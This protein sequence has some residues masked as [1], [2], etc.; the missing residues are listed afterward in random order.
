MNSTSVKLRVRLAAI[1][2]GASLLTGLLSAPASA[3]GPAPGVGLLVHNWWNGPMTLNIGFAQYMI[4][5]YG[6]GFVPLAAGTYDLSANVNG[7]DESSRDDRIVIPAGQAVEMSYWRNGVFFQT[8][9][10]VQPAPTAAGP[11]PPAN[12]NP[13]QAAPLD[14]QWHPIDGNQSLWYRFE[15]FSHDDEAFALAMP[16]TV[17][18]AL[19]FEIYSSDQISGWWHETPKSVGNIDGDSYTWGL[20]SGGGSVWYVRVINSGTQSTGFQF[21]YHGPLVT[22]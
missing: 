8:I 9:G 12:S 11:I 3:A 10:I 20:T 1:L 19:N 16:L 15:L 18:S 21:T 14:T 2:I 4:P 22:N 13:N 7:R 6:T 5:A 17:H